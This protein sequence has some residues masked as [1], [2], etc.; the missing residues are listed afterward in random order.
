V[1][2]SLIQGI[3]DDKFSARILFVLL[4]LECALFVFYFYRYEEI[5]DTFW[6]IPQISVLYLI[7]TL[8]SVLTLVIPVIFYFAISFY[9]VKKKSQSHNNAFRTI[10][11]TG[12]AIMGNTAV[13][14]T[15]LFMT[16]SMFDAN[17]GNIFSSLPTS[18]AGIYLAWCMAF[19]VATAHQLISYFTFERV[20]MIMN[21]D[22]EV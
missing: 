7:T 18:T 13:F 14:G 4:M 10:I 5:I 20:D 19:V 3:K 2:D 17:A 11:L 21:Q 15:E 22:A 8:F 1:I 12:F 6:D 9:F 16:Q